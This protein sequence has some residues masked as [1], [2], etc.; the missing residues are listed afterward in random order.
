MITVSGHIDSLMSL[1]IQDQRYV[2]LRDAE[3]LG[4]F[5][6][7]HGAS[8]LSDCDDFI[9]SQELFVS[10]NKASIDS[11]LFVE[12][13]CRPFKVGSEAIRFDAIDMVDDRKPFGIW[14]KRQSNDAVNHEV[15]GFAVSPKGDLVISST[16]NPGPKHLSIASLQSEPPHAYT[17]DASDSSKAADLVEVGE[18]DNRHASPFFAGQKPAPSLNIASH[19]MAD[20]AIQYGEFKCP[21]L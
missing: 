3:E 9:S 13:V 18:I 12:T 21:L 7:R 6:L 5:S 10:G 20:T 1:P 14:H 4:Y 16:S 11:M 19:N 17:I 8:E 2:G 15:T